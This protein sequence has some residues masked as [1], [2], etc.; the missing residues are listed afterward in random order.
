MNPN[1]MK[2]C[3]PSQSQRNK[4]R[5]TLCGNE[6]S[7]KISTKIYKDYIGSSHNYTSRTHT[8]NNDIPHCVQLYGTQSH[9]YL[10]TTIE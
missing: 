4:L 5:I 2:L 9:C 7:L 6:D 1:I 10:L 3:G 8:K